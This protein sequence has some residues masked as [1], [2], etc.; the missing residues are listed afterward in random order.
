MKPLRLVAQISEFID[1]WVID[2]IVDCVGFLP[3]LFGAAL[4]PIHNGFVQSYA[5]VML[6]G[7][8]VC[9]VTALRVLAGM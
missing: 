2:V 7:L 6:I 1:R 4:R 8:V 3:G 5:M 9:L